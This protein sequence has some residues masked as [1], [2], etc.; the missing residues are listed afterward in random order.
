[1]Q[2]IRHFVKCPAAIFANNFQV[3]IV[4]RNWIAFQPSIGTV[5]AQLSEPSLSLTGQ[6]ETVMRREN[7]YPD[8][9]HAGSSS[10]DRRQFGQVVGTS[11]VA[12]AAGLSGFPGTEAVRAAEK[13]PGKSTQKSETLVQKLYASMSDRQREELCFPWD[14]QDDRGLLRTHVSNNW[15]ITSDKDFNVASDFFTADQRDMVEAIFFGLY[16]AEWHDRIRKQLKDDAGGYGKRQS[17]AIF[18]KPGSGKFEFVMTGRH[19]TVRCDG[20]SSDHVALR[21]WR[22]PGR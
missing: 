12:A 7:L 16:N 9:M 3:V 2:Q 22:S 18:G 13:Q 11:A 4:G 8:R 1:M 19:L 6:K 15:H 14:Y 20:D 5:W 17:F 21:L 10:I